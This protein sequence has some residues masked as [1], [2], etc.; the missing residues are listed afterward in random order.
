MDVGITSPAV[1]DED[2][3]LEEGLEVRA[4]EEL[5]GVVVKEK[6]TLS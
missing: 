3:R 6:R 1:E 4:G 5:R 2:L